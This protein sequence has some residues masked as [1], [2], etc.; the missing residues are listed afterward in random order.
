MMLDMLRICLIGA[1]STGKTTL[2][3]ALAAHFG[4][5][6]VPEYAREFLTRNGG[7]CTLRDMIHIASSQVDAEE[8]LIRAARNL[9]FCDG[10]PLASMVWSRRYFGTAEDSLVQ[11][12]SKHGYALY[13]L[14]NIDLPWTVDGLRNSA[15][16]R[17]WLH[18][19]FVSALTTARSPY[20]L[21]SGA[22]DERLNAAVEA[23]NEEL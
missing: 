2:A 17:I 18:K 19:E 8:V 20:R 6:Y 16:Q 1:D 11:L 4:T 12:A 5:V 22:G 3:K 7:T 10:S 15:E 9:I 13:L 21:I 14:T 23:V